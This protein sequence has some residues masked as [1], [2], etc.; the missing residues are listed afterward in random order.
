MGKKV[1][2]GNRSNAKVAVEIVKI[3]MITVRE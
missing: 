1:A 3:G 2:K